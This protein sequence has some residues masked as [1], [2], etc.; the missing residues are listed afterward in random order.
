MYKVVLVDDEELII[1]GMKQLIN[2]KELECEVAGAAYDGDEALDI[3]NEVEPDI[4]ITDIRMPAMDGLTMIDYV[5]ERFPNL[6]IMIMSGY[7]DFEYA[8]QA[9]EKGAACY[10]LKPVSEKELSERIG[11]SVKRLKEREHQREEKEAITVRLYKLKREARISFLC[12]LLNE[13]S[14]EDYILE[15]WRGMEL[16]TYANRVR[17][18]VLDTDF[19][20][21]GPEA[22]IIKF[23]VDNIVEEICREQGYCESV[24]S[25][26]ERTVIF[27]MESS[28]YSEKHMF[29]ILKQII[30]TVQNISKVSVSIGVSKSVAFPSQIQDAYQDA[31]NALKKRFYESKPCELY[32][33][34][35]EMGKSFAVQEL[36]ETE[37][38]L[39]DTV[40]K[41]EKKNAM[42][43]L[44]RMFHNMLQSNMLPQ[45]YVYN[46]LKRI[47]IGYQDI[48]FKAKHTEYIGEDMGEFWSDYMYRFKLGDALKEWMAGVTE[49]I[50]E[51]LNKAP[52]EEMELIERIK[53][54]IS[55]NYRTAT[56]QS[57]ADY[58]FLNPSYLSQLFKA[59]TGEVFTDYVNKIR[60][61]EAKRMLIQ[62]DYKIQYIADM[63][64]YASSQ[65]FNRTFKKYTGMQPAEYKKNI[66]NQKG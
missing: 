63:V 30:E 27:I 55:K 9:L 23:A 13:V 24:S 51:C 49:R 65:H 40:E 64:G 39:L 8:H 28:E 22:S 21:K 44:G 37:N 56:R 58:F 25:G 19:P 35:I 18:A 54:Y 11:Q 45:E 1:E 16:C 41:G 43:V 66:Q 52:N 60:M 36:R 42:V 12:G 15:M 47:L 5:K 34:Q 59:E 2:W 38:L 14:F 26:D 48:L 4:L 53:Y 61:E 29:G 10:M 20:L 7:S 62:T 57:V 50:I 33:G 6:I 17:V 32:E 46:Q 31:L 3:I